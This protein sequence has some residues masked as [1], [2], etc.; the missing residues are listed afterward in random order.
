MSYCR[1]IFNA[2]LLFFITP[3]LAIHAQAEIHTQVECIEEEIDENHKT[4][5]IFYHQV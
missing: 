4:L 1:I 5:S 3:E 2:Q